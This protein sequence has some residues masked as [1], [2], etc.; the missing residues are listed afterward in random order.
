M[1]YRRLC[2][3]LAM[4]FLLPGC[5]IQEAP[6]ETTR[7]LSLV[8]DHLTAE[9]SAIINQFS[10]DHRV[11]VAIRILSPEEI[12]ATIKAKR[13]NADM[14]L[15]LTDN[16]ELRDQ[17]Y[18]L[19]AFRTIRDQQLFSKINRQFNNKHHYWL[20][21]SHDPLVVAAPL[22]TAGNCS[23]IDFRSWHRI[24]SLSPVV[25][26]RPPFGDYAA[27]LANSRQLTWLRI[28]APSK[29]PSDERIYRLSD[30]VTLENTIDSTYNKRMNACRNYIVDNQRYIT[31][32]YTVSLYVH[33][34][35]RAIAEK[36]IRIY[37]AKAYSV[38]S[39]RNQL[40]ANTGIQA[41]W[42]IRSLGIH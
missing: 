7:A 38:A 26:V 2:T 23:T 32:A 11:K 25:K 42:Y 1:K 22:D 10:F 40:P 31:R 12:I 33:G 6:E 4:A 41:S 17:L 34:R 8:A 14:D 21:L 35:N 27:L 19:G 29:R 37:A 9:D 30:L 5:W 36:F 15:I 18:T 39:G 13:Y 3:W 24:D 20:T 16:Q 28:D